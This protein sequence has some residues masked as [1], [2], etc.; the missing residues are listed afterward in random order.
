MLSAKSSRKSVLIESPVSLFCLEPIGEGAETEKCSISLGSPGSLSAGNDPGRFRGTYFRFAGFSFGV[1]NTKSRLSA[2]W[3]GVF[4]RFHNRE[5]NERINDRFKSTKIETTALNSCAAWVLRYLEG[6]FW[7]MFDQENHRY[8]LWAFWP[9]D[10]NS[11]Q[12]HQNKRLLLYLSWEMRQNLLNLVFKPNIKNLF[13]EMIVW[14]P[15]SEK[16]HPILYSYK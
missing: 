14:C 9:E 12:S 4:K 15:F 5:Q 6:T 3:W 1:T 7:S 2:R 16:F 13:E 8:V 11:I 10:P